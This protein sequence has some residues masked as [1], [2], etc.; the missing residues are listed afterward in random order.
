LGQLDINRKSLE[1]GTI[2]MKALMLVVKLA[3]IYH[4]L[5][6]KQHETGESVKN[7]P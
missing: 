7:I 1:I 5:T 2:W 4:L 3:P 6:Q